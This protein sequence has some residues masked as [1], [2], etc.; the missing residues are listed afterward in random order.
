MGQ[1]LVDAAGWVSRQAHEHVLEVA[2]WIVPIELGG[3][4]EAHDVGS[5]LT[6]SERAGK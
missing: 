5:A 1:E 2:I 4:D 6:G 3:L